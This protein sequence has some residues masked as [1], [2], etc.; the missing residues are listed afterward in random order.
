[1]TAELVPPRAVLFDWDNTL[2]ESWPTIHDALNHTLDAMG[3][4]VWTFEET[5]RRVRR[6]MRES[7]PALFG[8]RWSEAAEIFFGRFRA[9]HLDL[10]APADG[11]EGM[12]TA[13]AGRGLHLGV[14]SNKTGPLLR[15]E[16]AHLGWG[17][18]FAHVVGAADAERDKPAVEPVHMAL[19]GGGVAAG[20]AVW[21]VGDTDIDIA[22]ARNAG[23]RPVLL[24]RDPPW[25]DEFGTLDDIVHVTDCAALLSLLQKHWTAAAQS[26]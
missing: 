19:D 6:S 7:F 24:R 15:A 1:M 26:V 10:L 5:R 3:H 13:L 21:F 23:C 9:I 4:P 22:C 18:H 11:A 25:D 20:P 2:V 17:R 14:V 12:L 16:V 8:D